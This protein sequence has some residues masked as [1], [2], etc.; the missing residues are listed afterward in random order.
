MTN[1]APPVPP[2]VLPPDEVEALRAAG[3]SWD[4]LPPTSPDSA[5][6][7]ISPDLVNVEHRGTLPD[8]RYVKVVRAGQQGFDRLAPG[9]LQA[10]SRAT[11]A[12]GTVGRLRG[13]LRNAFIGAP[14]STSQFVHERL[15]KV[16]ALAVL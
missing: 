1:D 9:L 16:K 2:V 14:L 5:L 7:P 11:A 12:S 10:T 3:A 13:R 8:A 15:T 6:W 4:K